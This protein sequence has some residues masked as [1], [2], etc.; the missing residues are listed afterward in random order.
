MGCEDCARCVPTQCSGTDIKC[1]R[2]GCESVIPVIYGMPAA[3]TFAAEQEGRLKLGGIM[4]GEDSPDWLCRECGHEWPDPEC[5][6]RLF[7][8]Y[9]GKE[10]VNT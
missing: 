3:M 6:K 9:P 10:G 2:C 4:M 7:S 5:K 1:I 8:G